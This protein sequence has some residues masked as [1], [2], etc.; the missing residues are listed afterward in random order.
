MYRHLDHLTT[1]AGMAMFVPYA[2]AAHHRPP[3]PKASPSAHFVDDHGSLRVYRHPTTA[4][5]ELVHCAIRHRHL[6]VNPEHLAHRDC[7]DCEHIWREGYREQHAAAA[8]AGG[9]ASTFAVTEL[10]LA[11]GGTADVLLHIDEIPAHWLTTQE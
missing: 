7:T 10:P 6:W 8:A 4:A 5:A 2:F 1:T 3:S 11:V 9:H